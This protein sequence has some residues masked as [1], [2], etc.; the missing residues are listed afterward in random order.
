MQLLDLGRDARSPQGHFY[1]GGKWLFSRCCLLRDQAAWHISLAEEACM[2]HRLD[3]IGWCK[4]RDEPGIFYTRI[5]G[6]HRV[7]AVAPR[8]AAGHHIANLH[9]LPSGPISGP[10]PVNTWPHLLFECSSPR[11]QAGCKYPEILGLTPLRLQ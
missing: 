11:F 6:Y 3:R 4:C 2:S 9:P 8:G 1:A 7:Y 5:P 10:R